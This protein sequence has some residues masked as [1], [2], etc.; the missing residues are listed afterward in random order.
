MNHRSKISKVLCK[1]HQ[2]LGDP[3]TRSE[4][5]PKQPSELLNEL[6]LGK[7]KRIEVRTI[8]LEVFDQG[9]NIG[10]WWKWDSSY[11]SIICQCYRIWNCTFLIKCVNI[12]IQP[13]KD[14]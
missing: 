11:Y 9:H 5:I 8:Q 12:I 2:F 1:Q 14:I 13:E 6:L 3:G 10:L 4:K 7:L